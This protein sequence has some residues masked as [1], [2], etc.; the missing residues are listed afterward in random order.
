MKLFGLFIMILGLI[1]IWFVP[2]TPVVAWV[3]IIVGLVI[4]LAG[5]ILKSKA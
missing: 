1:L 3:L 2:I 5:Y 4:L